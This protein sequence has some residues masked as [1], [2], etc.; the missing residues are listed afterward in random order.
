MLSKILVKVLDE[1]RSVFLMLIW[2][3]IY[4]VHKDCGMKY[5]FTNFSFTSITFK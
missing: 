2:K 4:N 5:C 3:F 1:L